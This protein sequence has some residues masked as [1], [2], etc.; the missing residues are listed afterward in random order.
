[1]VPEILARYHQTEVSSLAAAGLVPALCGCAGPCYNV[2]YPQCCLETGGHCAGV[3][4]VLR[5]L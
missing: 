5:K 3:W 1:M 2:Q 4:P